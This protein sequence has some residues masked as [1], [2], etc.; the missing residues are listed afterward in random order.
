MWN[1][2]KKKSDT[3]TEQGT[4]YLNADLAQK[5]PKWFIVRRQR[6]VM[7]ER[8]LFTIYFTYILIIF[9]F[10]DFHY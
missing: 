9:Y 6:I 8:S 2:I 5:A 3:F 1:W 4:R 10:L 7:R